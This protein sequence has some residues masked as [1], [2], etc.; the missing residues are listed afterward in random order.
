[1]VTRERL[2]S[3][4]QTCLHISPFP[5]VSERD[6]RS[7]CVLGR[8]RLEGRVIGKVHKVEYKD[9]WTAGVTELRRASGCVGVA[10]LDDAAQGRLLWASGGNRTQKI[11]NRAVG[12]EC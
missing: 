6:S 9:K 2:T 10:A 1:M 8:D 12:S 11:L 3:E 4:C 5:N 7:R